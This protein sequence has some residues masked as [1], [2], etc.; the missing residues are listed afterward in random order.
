MA[1][2]EKDRERKY[3]NCSWEIWNLGL[4]RPRGTSV[5]VTQWLLAHCWSRL[6][7]Y[8]VH[9]WRTCSSACRSCMRDS[10]ILLNVSNFDILIGPISDCT[11]WHLKDRRSIA[12]SVYCSLATPYCPPHVTRKADS[13]EKNCTQPLGLGSAI[14]KFHVPIPRWIYLTHGTTESNWVNAHAQLY[15]NLDLFG[16][17]P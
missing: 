2:H 5:G 8:S 11:L 16:G 1:V 14:L 15:L 17:R 12:Y 10:S 13:S 7:E 3:S 4:P 6:L 9:I